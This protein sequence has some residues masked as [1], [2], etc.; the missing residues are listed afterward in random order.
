MPVAEV[1]AGLAR[2]SRPEPTPAL[3]ERVQSRSR[4]ADKCA[5]FPS[6]GA[7]GRWGASG[8]R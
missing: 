3:I 2:P 7:Q 1:K 5:P 4:Q 6:V 8:L